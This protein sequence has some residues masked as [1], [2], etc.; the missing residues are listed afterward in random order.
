MA[1]DDPL[2]LFVDPA[3][4]CPTCKGTGEWHGR[5]CI[6]CRGSGLEATRPDPHTDPLPEG[7]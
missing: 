2:T 7:F 4:P 3:K 5:R 6:S 1:R